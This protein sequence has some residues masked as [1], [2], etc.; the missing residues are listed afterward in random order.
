MEGALSP[1]RIVLFALVKVRV[2]SVA[3]ALMFTLDFLLPLKIKYKEEYEKTK[4]RVLGT[5]DS[6]LLHSLQVAKM[7][8]EVSFPVPN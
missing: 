4:G 6:K 1:P 8:S 2:P 3:V 7:S 5:S